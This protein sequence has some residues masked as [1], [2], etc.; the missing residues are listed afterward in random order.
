MVDR[1][2]VSPGHHEH[3]DQAC[4]AALRRRLHLHPVP[5]GRGRGLGECARSHAHDKLHAPSPAWRARQ[6]RRNRAQ[7]GAIR[8]N[9]SPQAHAGARQAA[10]G[11]VGGGGGGG[12]GESGE[13]TWPPAALPAMLPAPA[14]AAAAVGVTGVGRSR[15]LHPHILPICCSGRS[16]K[17]DRSDSQI[18][19]CTDQDS[20][21][22]VLREQIL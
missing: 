7:S 5:C 21:R 20:I 14:S 17:P 9:R 2:K 16:C 18:L 19:T 6:S 3:D 22:S 8:R 12:S 13:S 1:R 15:T 4:T 10:S 11:G